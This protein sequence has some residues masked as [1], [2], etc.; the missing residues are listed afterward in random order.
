MSHVPQRRTSRSLLSISFAAL[1]GIACDN[2]AAIAD[3]AAPLNDWLIQDVCAGAS[4]RP[5]MADPYKG[6]PSG[7]TERDLR[8]GEPIPYRK[9]DQT[10]HQ[11]HDS[12]PVIDSK[13]RLLVVNPFD[14]APFGTFDQ[15][16][17][18]YDL[19]EIRNG[20]ASVGETRDS[21]G[22]ATTF[23]GLGCTPFNGWV[24]FPDT[25]SV[26]NYSAI[27]NAMVPIAGVHWLQAG[28]PWPGASRMT[29]NGC[30]AK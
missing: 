18:G 5:I 3:S 28:Q 30:I 11:E 1:A 27:G 13:A 23:F 4:G 24:F 15:A 22:Y 14:Y 26:S 16:T 8:A 9:I 29:T 7:T 20:W 2:S 17:D 10:G 19:Y 25:I 21:G 12:Y 6:C